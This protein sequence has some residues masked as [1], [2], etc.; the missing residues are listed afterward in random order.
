MI[1]KQIEATIAPRD[2]NLEIIKTI[3]NAPKQIAAEKG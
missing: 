2:T 1:G 3:K